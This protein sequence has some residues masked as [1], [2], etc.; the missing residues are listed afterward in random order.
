[1]YFKFN[2]TQSK[3]QEKD[4]EYIKHLLKLKDI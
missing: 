2:S 1:M 4:P 3:I